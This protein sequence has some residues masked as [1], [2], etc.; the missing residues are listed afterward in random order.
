MHQQTIEPIGSAAAPVANAASGTKARFPVL[1]TRVT[2]E[3]EGILSFEFRDPEGRDLPP[4]T[5]GAHLEIQ[6]SDGIIR[7]YSLCNDPAERHRY[8]VAVLKEESGRG[9]SRAMHEM[10]GEGARLL[11]L[12]P[13]NHFPLAGREARRHLLVAGGI[14]VTPMIAMIAELENRGAQWSMHYCTRSPERTAFLDQLQPFVEAGKV[15]LHHDGGDPAKGLDLKAAL[16]EFGVGTHLYYCGPPGFMAACAQCLE[17]WPPHAV[18]REYFASP[19]AEQD[20]ATREPFQ[21]KLNSTGEILDVP[22]D[23]SIADVLR[24]TGSPVE[25]DCEDGYCGTCITRYLAGTP[26]HR[27]TVLSEKE[28]RSY[29]MVCCARARGGVIELDL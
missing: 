7:S 6:I 3:A 25:T 4:F 16:S 13:R 8:V 5:A 15:F 11:V 26:E 19:A 1:V 23:R 9:G 21:V 2:R 12:P 24:S 14:G 22:A 10:I 17:P 20:T 27:D 18:H 29:L 28:R